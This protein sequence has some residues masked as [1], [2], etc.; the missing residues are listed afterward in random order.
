[1]FSSPF[2]HNKQQ[3]QFWNGYVLAGEA[4]EVELFF[5][6]DVTC[7]GDLGPGFKQ[8]SAAAETKQA[9]SAVQRTEPQGGLVAL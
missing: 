7:E 6:K 9:L 1:M 3:K 4:E 5:R 8:L 2:P